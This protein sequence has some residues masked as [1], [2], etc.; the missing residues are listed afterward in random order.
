MMVVMN[1]SMA[2][3]G[4]TVLRMLLDPG[5]LLALFWPTLTIVED[6]H[7]DDYLQQYLQYSPAHNFISWLCVYWQRGFTTLTVS[8]NLIHP[9]TEERLLLT[10]TEPHT[11]T[12]NNLLSH[13]FAHYNKHFLSLWIIHIKNIF[14]KEI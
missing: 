8:D 1:A 5:L 11:S 9:S 6:D 14:C 10:V 4:V 2:R 7:T 13:Y 3:K 12:N